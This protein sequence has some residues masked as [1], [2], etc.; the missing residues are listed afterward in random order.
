MNSVYSFTDFSAVLNHAKVGQFAF[1]GEG[2]NNCVVA[3]A[4]DLT[5]HDIAADGSVMSSKQVSR[6]G[7][8][9]FTVQQT[10][11]AHRFLLKW[12]AYLIAAPTSEWTKTNS[13]ITNTALG[14][15]Y[16]C[17]GISPQ[18]IPDDSHQQAGQQVTWT[19]MA[20]EIVSK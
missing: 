14:I 13:V 9:A 17:K 7:T 6:S 10:S 12:S 16:D 11:A 15:T 8:I 1:Q 20:Q 5:A 18:K 2:V 4:N 3:F 19:L